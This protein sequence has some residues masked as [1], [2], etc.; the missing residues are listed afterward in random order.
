MD[1]KDLGPA[2][3]AADPTAQAAPKPIATDPSK[4]PSQMGDPA[5]GAGTM[6]AN[7]S[8]PEA[9]SKPSGPGG[10][11][12]ECE[13]PGNNLNYVSDSG[14]GNDSECPEADGAPIADGERAFPS[15]ETEVRITSRGKIRNYVT[16]AANL[17]LTK[18]EKAIVVRGLGNVINKT[19]N[20][21]EVLKR[22]VKGLYQVTNIGSLR[23]TD[24]VEARDGR[25]A[26]QRTTL[27]AV[28]SILLTTERPD[29][30]V[31]CV[32]EPLP[33]EEI[34]PLRK[35]SSGRRSM[36]NRRAA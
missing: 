29:A 1:T 19:V 7:A 2:Q 14:D 23:I 12:Q 36:R 31:P 26:R 3:R 11:A 16:F 28:I 9:R 21:A 8:G 4:E 10:D 17:F 32:Q 27:V 18:N 20:L 34:Q 15:V 13:A 25:P 35:P 6:T 5:E 22:R 24:A 30:S 33:E